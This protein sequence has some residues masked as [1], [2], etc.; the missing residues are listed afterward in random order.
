[1]SEP[2]AYGY[3]L[4]SRLTGLAPDAVLPEDMPDMRV[5]GR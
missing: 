2:S 4:L 1:L 3:R 5:G